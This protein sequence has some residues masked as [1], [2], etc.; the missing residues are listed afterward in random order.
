[1]HE[2]VQT[3]L[4]LQEDDVA[5][6][7]IEEEMNALAPRLFDLDRVRQVTAD[8]LDRARGLLGAEEKRLHDLQIRL[9]EQKQAHERN[10]HNLDLV[11]KA[12]EAAAAMMQVET[13]RKALAE[14]ES[15]LLATSR[16]LTDARAA[17][18]TQQRGLAEL[19]A[20]QATAR[21][22]IGRERAALDERLREARGK[23]AGIAQRVA[24]PL[25][26]KYDRIRGRKRVQA[27]YPLRGGSC[28]NCDTAIPMQRRNVM[29]ASGQI[30]VCEAC[31]VLL[32]AGE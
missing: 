4:A 14:T 10:L 1:V 7:S 19:E 12:K 17:V 11:K 24:R 13:T 18:E 6:H 15:D 23:R 16:R 20:S 2:D 32:Y 8:A 29:Q 27:I 30:E 5:I 21:E 3:L 22:E 25:L 28:G 9:A 26:A 31:G